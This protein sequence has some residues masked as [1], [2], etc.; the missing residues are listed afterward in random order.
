MSIKVTLL[1]TDSR[2]S[3]RGPVSVS[4]AVRGDDVRIVADVLDLS[5]HGARFATMEPLTV[6]AR[7][8]FKLPLS[9]TMTATIIWASEGEAG[10]R[11]D[12]PLSQ[13]RFAVLRQSVQQF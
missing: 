7:I 9:E 8:S 2:R 1:E 6:G 12:E 4:A 5:A 11:F 13:V 3:G 10:C